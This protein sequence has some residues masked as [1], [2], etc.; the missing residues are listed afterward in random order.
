MAERKHRF[1][2]HEGV[3]DVE[4]AVAD[5]LVTVG[6]KGYETS[7]PIEIRALEQHPLVK[8]VTG[9]QPAREEK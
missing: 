8:P 4:I 3:N 9:K 5:G 1:A 7:D 6:E 2:A